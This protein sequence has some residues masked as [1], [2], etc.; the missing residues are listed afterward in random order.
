[1]P[2][3]IKTKFVS[4]QQMPV[5]GDQINNEESS[6]KEPVI[7]KVS[8]PEA[9]AAAP[10]TN[11]ETETQTPAAAEPLSLSVRREHFEA[12]H[13]IELRRAGEETVG[14]VRMQDSRHT[15]TIGA[16]SVEQIFAENGAVVPAA[17]ET[18]QITFSPYDGEIIAITKSQTEK[19]G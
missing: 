12:P 2:K 10:D 18:F 8:E 15:E 6:V 7:G 4:E 19:T 5:I 17:D 16:K 11:A 3:E 14:E 9:S 13:F 1:M